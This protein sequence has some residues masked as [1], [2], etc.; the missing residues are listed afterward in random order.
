MTNSEFM[1]HA[2]YQRRTC[3]EVKRKNGVVMFIPLDPQ[4]GLRIQRMTEVVFGESYK[5][6]PSYPLEKACRVYLEF[7]RLIGATKE[8]LGYLAQIIPFNIEE[9]TNMTTATAEAP[10]E[11]TGEKTKAATKPKKTGEKRQ[12]AAQ[13]FQDLILEGKLTD[14]QIFAR[15]K[16][17]YGL[18]D[19]KRGYVGWYR[20]HLKKLGKKPP[21]PV[22]T[23]KAK[24]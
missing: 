19:K 17:K 6:M 15:V 1:V 9:F 8:S 12:S 24:E 4:V 10:A 21:E 16:A 2:D 11:K 3:L 22:E 18:D 13:L 20:N 5:P 23:K 7:A 14:N